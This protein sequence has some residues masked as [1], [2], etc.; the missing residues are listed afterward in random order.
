MGSEM[1]IR[2]RLWAYGEPDIKDSLL[3]IL[4]TTNEGATL[5]DRNL[6]K[7]VYAKTGSLSGVTTFSGYILNDPS[8]PIAFSILMNGFKGSSS[9]FRALQD[10][11]VTYLSKVNQL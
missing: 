7:G 4:S 3:K 1:C 2:D 6:P 5:K 10:E 9:A 11:I 8:D